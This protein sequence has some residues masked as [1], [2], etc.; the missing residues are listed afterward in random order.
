[1][2]TTFTNQYINTG[3][4]PLYPGEEK[5]QDVNLAPSLTL[6]K[7]TVLGE[8]QLSDVWSLSTGSQGSGTFT[9]TFGGV[10]T[11]AN[12][13][14]VSAATLQS[15]LRALAPIGSTGVSVAL[16]S[17]TPGTNAVY[18]ISFA[19]G[20]AFKTNGALTANFAS[21]ATP[22]NASLTQST[23]GQPLGTFTTYNN[24]NSDGSQTAAAILQYDCASDSS[25][26]VTLGTASTGGPYGQ[27]YRAVPAFFRGTFRTSELVGL[28]A[29][30]V[31]DLGRL[32]EGT[33]SA[34]ILR[35]P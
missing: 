28:D 23:V 25:G 32:I 10:T 14:N 18:T 31:T 30:A 4:V 29:A 20:L 5:C 11:A 19:G 24:G 15:N 35:M 3:L 22:G 16:A 8:I 9:L 27:K 34:G 26:L 21:L 33:L 2:A 1:M 12:A 13:F 6:T 7:G 17:G